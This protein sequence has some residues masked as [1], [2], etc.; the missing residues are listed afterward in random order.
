M[1]QHRGARLRRAAA[2]AQRA[3][4]GRRPAPDR[5]LRTGPVQP[6]PLDAGGHRHLD[7][8]DPKA[9]DRARARYA[10]FD[11]SLGDDGQAYGYAAAFGAGPTCERQAVEQL[12]ELQ[13]DAAKYLAGDGRLAEDELFY[14]QQNAT[15][16]RNAEAYYRSMFRGRVTSWNMRDKHMAQTLGALVA[17]LDAHGGPEPA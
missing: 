13:R 2:L 17:H 9:A 4:G 3:P 11:H 5:L 10:C 1:A 8:V 16:V 12:V 15:T 6:A 14:A 7:D